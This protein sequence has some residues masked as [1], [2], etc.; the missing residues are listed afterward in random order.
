MLLIVSA[1]FVDIFIMTA[2]VVLYL[3]RRFTRGPHWETRAQENEKFSLPL[4]AFHLMW[5]LVF[6]ILVIVASVQGTRD[7][8]TRTVEVREG[9]QRL[10]N[11]TAV[12]GFFPRARAIYLD[13]LVRSEARADREC[14]GVMCRELAARFESVSTSPLSIFPLHLSTAVPC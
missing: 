2:R 5:L 14:G 4:L 6:V 12:W 9:G 10:R 7:P 8:V 1:W 11:S 3:R 13:L